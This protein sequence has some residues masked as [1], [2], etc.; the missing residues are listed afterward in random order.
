MNNKLMSHPEYG[1]GITNHQTM[2]DSALKELGALDDHILAYAN[3]MSLR[4]VI[5]DEPYTAVTGMEDVIHWLGKRENYNGLVNYI[6]ELVAAQG[7]EF[8]VNEL[9]PVLA[10]GVSGGAMHPIIRLGHAVHDE[11]EDEV[12]AA[13]AYWAWAYQELAW[14]NSRV[15]AHS[16]LADVIKHLLDGVIW[17]DSRFDCA[18][19]AAEFEAVVASP[20]YPG[21]V[22][23]VT[24]E[25][26]SIDSL[27]QIALAALW[28]HDDFTLL[29]GVIS[30][31]AARRIS[32]WLDEPIILLEPMWKALVIAWLSKGLRW[33][34]STLPYSPKLSIDQI[35]AIA[36]QGMR[37]HTVKL[38]AAC[39]DM[40]QRTGEVMYLAVAEREVLGDETLV[41]V[42]RELLGI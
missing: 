42:R 28:M 19:I 30:L 18:T 5:S 15:S 41:D 3:K 32:V 27:E 7:V 13:L 11:S 9:V 2:V 39:L 8:T 17:P 10:A 21:L 33:N 38:V 26:L 35:R 6:R 4:T 22:F 34:N 29:H 23:R 31:H 24:P 25:L 20:T 14:P 16:S 37:D 36:R 1:N 40:Y 12:I